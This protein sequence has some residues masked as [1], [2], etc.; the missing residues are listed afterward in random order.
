M[1]QKQAPSMIFPLVKPLPELL[2]Q[3]RAR[4]EILRQIADDPEAKLRFDVLSPQEQD[5]LL[6]FCMNRFLSA[7]LKQPVKVRGILPREGMQFSAESSFMVM[8]IPLDIFLQ[9]PHNELTELEAWLY[10]LGS[11]NPVHIQQI[12]EKYPFF[13]ELYQDI[14]NLRYHPKELISMYSEALFVADQ[15]TIKLMIDE[16]KQETSPQ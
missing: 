10:F 9:R 13:R 4:Q 2:G 14:I 6:D 12:I 7:I 11:D 8:Y 16:L 3:P 15:N 1:H 5:T